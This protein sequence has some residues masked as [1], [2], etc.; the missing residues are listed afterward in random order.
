MVKISKIEITIEKK[1]VRLTGASIGHKLAK[2]FGIVIYK[3][4]PLCITVLVL[5]CE[6]NFMSG[7]LSIA[8]VRHLE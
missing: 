4:R 7:T 1:S 8:L 2:S 5:R 6:S 3:Q